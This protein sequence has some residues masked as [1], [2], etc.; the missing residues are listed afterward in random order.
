MHGREEEAR[1]KRVGQEEREKARAR[2]SSEKGDRGSG[3]T[4]KEK[5][6]KTET[7]REFE[8]TGVA[9][10]TGWRMPRGKK[11]VV[12]VTIATTENQMDPHAV[13]A[14]LP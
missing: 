14:C 13:T 4:E 5:V 10:R 6:S 3:E 9:E 7:G 12:E 1:T 8:R 2:G 11:R